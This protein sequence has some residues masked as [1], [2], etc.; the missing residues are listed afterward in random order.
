MK[1]FQDIVSFCIF[2]ILLIIINNGKVA[3]KKYLLVKMQSQD[4]SGSEG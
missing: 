3:S 2:S 1:K 4:D